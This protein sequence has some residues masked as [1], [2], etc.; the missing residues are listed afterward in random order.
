MTQGELDHLRESC[1]I[2]SGIQIR[3]PE[4][5][6]TIASTRLGEVAF[7]EA[8]FQA[9]LHLPIHPTIRRIL[10]YYNICPTQL[11]PNAWQSIVGYPSNVNGWKKTFFFILEDNWEFAHEKSQG[12]GVTRVPRSWG[13]PG[14]HC[15]M[16][17]TLTEIEVTRAQAQK[18]NQI[19]GCPLSS[20]RM[21]A[22]RK[23]LAASRGEEEEASCQGQG[24]VKPGSKQGGGTCRNPLGEDLVQ[25]QGYLGAQHLCHGEP[26]HCKEAPLM[27]YFA[28]RPRGCGEIGPRLGDH[29]V[30]S[31]YFGKG[32]DL[33]KKQIGHLHSALDIQD[34]QIH[35][36]LV[37]EDEGE[38][39]C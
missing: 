7:Y 12:L 11:A 18:P 13:T 16:L 15:N 34:L 2:V 14:K 5:D 21:T 23:G 20:D 39:K 37:E 1:S 6:E 28:C 9:S 36:E 25:S 8:A 30:A 3:L 32:F 38:E 27:A 33:C 17:P 29:E 24:N 31:K 35:P 26:W 10:A 19:Q 4:A 22:R